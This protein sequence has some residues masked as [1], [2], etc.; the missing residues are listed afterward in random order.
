MGFFVEAGDFLFHLSD[1]ILYLFFF[2]HDELGLLLVDGELVIGGLDLVGEFVLELLD[3][4]PEYDDGVFELG[5]LLLAHMGFQEHLL[6]D[7]QLPD[8]LVDVEVH[9]F[10]KLTVL[11]DFVSE[12]LEHVV[13]GAVLV[14]RL[15]RVDQ[16]LL[17]EQ[18]LLVGVLELLSLHLQL[19]REPCLLLLLL[20]QQVGDFEQGL[21]LGLLRVLVLE[22]VD[23]LY[24]LGALLF[25]LCDL[26]LELHGVHAVLLPCD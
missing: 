13:G 15:P 16:P 12:R 9:P 1:F 25:H 24:E 7:L 19:L 21:E 14:Q 22:D 2:P 10:L 4:F 11:A 23:L 5:E 6:G 18:Q 17:R 20:A 8:L 26:L 3:V